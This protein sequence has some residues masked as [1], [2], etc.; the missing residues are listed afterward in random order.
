[1]RTFVYCL[2]VVILVGAG[3]CVYEAPLVEEHALPVDKAVL[4]IWR[5]ANDDGDE[6]GK[7][8]EMMVLMF[9][10]TEYV[11]HY[12]RGKHGL[13]YRAYPIKVG[14]ISCVQLEVIG[15]E[16]GPLDEDQENRFHVV[17]YALEGDRLT[18]KVLN[19][20]LVNDELTDSESLRKAFLEH[21]RSADLFTNP[22]VFRRV[23]K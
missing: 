7:N 23:D 13:Y 11:I 15:T 16:E 2:T 8:N 18:I 9:S 5:E 4:G 12:P 14:G 17:S 22:G 6:E 21:K 10:P 3:A 19:K 1:M 20:D